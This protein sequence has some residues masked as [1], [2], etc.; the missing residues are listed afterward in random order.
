MKR[1][2]Q[3]IMPDK[4]IQKANNYYITRYTEQKRLSKTSHNINQGMKTL[5]SE[6]YHDCAFITYACLI[7]PLL[8]KGHLR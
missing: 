8:H 3:H 7:M 1:L 2:S 5:V 4:N 6:D